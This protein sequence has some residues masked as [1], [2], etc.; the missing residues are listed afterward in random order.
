MMLQSVQYQSVKFDDTDSISLCSVSECQ[1]DDTD[2]I[3]LCSVSECQFD[4]T[5]SIL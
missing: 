2:S 3:S 4:D 1:F 5:D